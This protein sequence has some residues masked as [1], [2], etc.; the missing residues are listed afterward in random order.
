[1]EHADAATRTRARTALTDHL[2][3]HEAPDGRVRLLSTAW[4][5]TA[6]R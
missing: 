6:V 1:M 5:V 2:R 3:P 4:L